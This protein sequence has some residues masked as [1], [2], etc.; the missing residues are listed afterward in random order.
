MKVFTA[1]GDVYSLSKEDEKDIVRRVEE[2]NENT[3]RVYFDGTVLIHELDGPEEDNIEKVD[4]DSVF[5][6]VSN[7]RMHL[8]EEY[9]LEPIHKNNEIISDE[10]VGLCSNR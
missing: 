9:G 2:S 8:R 7:H 3:K 5:D 6:N 10:E 4:F 1:S